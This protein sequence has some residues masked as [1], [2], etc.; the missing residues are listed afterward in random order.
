M[1]KPIQISSFSMLFVFCTS[2]FSG[3]SG[4]S[5]SGRK[6]LHQQAQNTTNYTPTAKNIPNRP[7]PRTGNIADLTA[8][9]EP[10]VFLV[11]NFDENGNQTGLGTGFFI[12]N[13]TGIAVS[14][15]HVFAG[16][17]TWSVKLID[18]TIHR[19]V[20]ILKQSTE[21]DYV[22]FQVEGNNFQYLP[23]AQN[24]PRKGEE[25]VVLGNPEGLERDRK[26]VV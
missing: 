4:C 26:S 7:L 6:N 23:I 3:C 19:V 8:F 18:G 17:T 10:C 12:K 22:V 25:I 2:A 1:I 21:E 9:A 14:N 11:G 15:A 24:R 5:Q 16:G 13:T 20:N